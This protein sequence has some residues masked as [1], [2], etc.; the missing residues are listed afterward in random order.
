ME[1]G[2]N[3]NQPRVAVVERHYELVALTVN[4][5]HLV[6]AAAVVVGQT[7]LDGF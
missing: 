2:I 4:E 3:V 6:A 7:H 5:K 1:E